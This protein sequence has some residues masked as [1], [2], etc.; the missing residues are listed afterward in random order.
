MTPTSLNCHIS[1]FRVVNKFNSFLPP[2][3]PKQLEKKNGDPVQI[4][5]PVVNFSEVPQSICKEIQDEANRI[6]RD[7]AG[8]AHGPEG[9]NLYMIKNQKRSTEPHIVTYDVKKSKAT[10]T[11]K[12]CFRAKGFG[13]C[14]HAV[15]V[16]YTENFIEDFMRQF[17]R[18]KAKNAVSRLADVGKETGAGEKKSKATQKRKGPANAR[19]KK[20][21]TCVNPTEYVGSDDVLI[22]NQPN[23]SAPQF[24]SVPPQSVPPQSVRPQ[25]YF[26]QDQVFYQP[27][28]QN[29]SRPPAFPTPCAGGYVLTLL[30]F[31]HGNVTSCYSCRGKFLEC[32]YP[33]PPM[34]MIVVSNTRRW[35][36]ETNSNQMVRSTGLTNVYFHLNYGCLREFDR[37]FTPQMISVPAE[38]RPFLLPEHRNI[39]NSCSIQI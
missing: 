34:D 9:S 22:R 12:S 39:L 21:R 23:L 14:A 30:K 16:A 35:Y 37:M 27:Q 3:P 19:P 7:D 6:L 24:Q 25:Q 15:A 1:C 29:A 38:V 10:C 2:G 28:Q 5:L 11:S 17:N 8:L 18:N 26:Q 4:R 33:N 32:G 13:V 36:R 31:C 20:V